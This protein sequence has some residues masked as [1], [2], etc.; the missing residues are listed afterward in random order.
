MRAVDVV[1][2]INV[3]MYFVVVT[4]LFQLLAK[5]TYVVQLLCHVSDLLTSVCKHVNDSS[6]TRHHTQ[7]VSFATIKLLSLFNTRA[8]TNT[9]DSKRPV[10]LSMN[11]LLNIE[12]LMRFRIR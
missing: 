5:H 11:S 8:K 4:L 3:F 6:A 2:G 7:I 12:I 9:I 10:L 1:D